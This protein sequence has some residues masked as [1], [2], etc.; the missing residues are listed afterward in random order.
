MTAIITG[1]KWYLVVVLIGVSPSF[2]AP[3]GQLHSVSPSSHVPVGHPY[4][5]S[6]SSHAP[7]GHPFDVSPSSHVPI[8]H[9]YVVFGEM[10]HLDLQ[11]ISQLDCLGVFCY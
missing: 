7:I 10:S 8:G 3:I 11:P 5:V 4:G 6:P 1:V 2:H 9:L